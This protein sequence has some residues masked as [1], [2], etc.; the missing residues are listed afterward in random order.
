MGKIVLQD[1]RCSYVFVTE[2]SKNGG[3]GVQPLIPKGSKLEKRI[4]AE[5]LKV[6]AEKHGEKAL[7]TKGKFKLP[8]RDGDDERDTPEYEGMMF[9]NAN[10]GKKNGKKPGLVNRQGDPADEADIEDYCYSGAYFHVSINVYG[11]DSV[12]GGK[13]GVAMG[14]NNLMLRKKGKRLDGSIA[15]TDEFA[16]FADDEDDDDDFDL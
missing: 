10:C 15:A 3:Y 4:N 12:D 8:L 1:V 7:K 6:L 2:E 14:L 9:F 16:D 13:P 5:V 11:Y